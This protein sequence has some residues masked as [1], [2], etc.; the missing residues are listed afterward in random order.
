MVTWLNSRVWN[1]EKQAEQQTPNGRR[2]LIL[3]WRFKK[4]MKMWSLRTKP[5]WEA[6]W[7]Q[8]HHFHH[9]DIVL[10]L[11]RSRQ[12]LDSSTSKG[13]NSEISPGHYMH[14]R[15]QATRWL[16][17]RPWVWIKLLLFFCCSCRFKWWFSIFLEKECWFYVLF[18][19]T[20]VIDCSVKCN[21][22]CFYLMFVNGHPVQLC[23]AEIMFT[24]E[25]RWHGFQRSRKF[26]HSLTSKA[27]MESFTKSKLSNDSS[28]KR[29]KG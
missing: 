1:V 5:F 6:Q 21:G 26:Q 27:G 10:E 24:E 3:L 17:Q 2:C 20:Y 9:K 11:S 28:S 8:N 25:R 12:W 29:I 18:Q 7:V 13:D 14:I 23:L 22:F 4:K 15:D 19:S 16:H